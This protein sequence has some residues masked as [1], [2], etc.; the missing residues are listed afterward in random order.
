MLGLLTIECANNLALNNGRQHDLLG[1]A[2]EVM[3]AAANTSEAVWF[4]DG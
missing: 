2:N 3:F 1:W 4:A